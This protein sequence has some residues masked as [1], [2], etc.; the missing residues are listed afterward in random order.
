MLQKKEVKKR[1]AVGLKPFDYGANG[2][3]TAVIWES[4]PY[5]CSFSRRV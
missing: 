2:S 1:N 5:A 3:M 4:G